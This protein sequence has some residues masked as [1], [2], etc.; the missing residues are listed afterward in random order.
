MMRNITLLGA[1]GSVGA[2][3]LD[4]IARYPE[5]Y[6][7]HAVTAQSNV[8]DLAD[9]AVKFSADIAVIGNDDLERPLR[10]ALNARGARTIARAG[11]HALIEVAN[12]PN[13]D[14]VLAAIVGSAGLEPTLAAAESGKRLLLANKEA[15]VCAGALLMAAV[16]RGGGSLLPVDSEHNAIH[17]C[18]SGVRATERAGVRLV[19]TASG[20]PF[21][22]RDDLDE[23]TP[24]QAC[25][26]PKWVMGRKISVDSA[27]LMNKGLEVI[28]ASWLF[29]IP[30]DRIDIVIHPQS[31]IHSMVE[32]ADGSVLAQM[33]SPDMRTPLAYAL[34]WPERIASGAKRLDFAHAGPLTFE[35]PDRRRFRCLDYAYAALGRGGGA[36]VVLNAANEIAVQAF[37][38]QRLRFTEIAPTIEQVL[39]SYDPPPPQSFDDVIEI[40]REA[41]ER[42]G[43]CV[44]EKIR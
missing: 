39:E 36:S 4:I 13:C 17:Q 11:R 31:V 33:G 8:D 3:A 22:N 19:L 27:T 37:L 10:D 41:R 2:S 30:A 1:T 42:A 5:R 25:A 24:D 43:D 15:I 18:L 16:Q 32:F 44:M 20:G 21:L 14:T 7:V 29:G 9:I 34:A 38:E 23:V 6:R 12:T 26:H 28:E 40:D 35:A